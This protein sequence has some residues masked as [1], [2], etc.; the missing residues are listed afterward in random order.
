[1]V[2]SCTD[3]KDVRQCPYSL[4]EADFD[5]DAATLPR[6]QSIKNDAVERG[7]A[8]GLIPYGFRCSS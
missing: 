8:A 3:E 4:T 2:S 1:M 5:D 6:T 7:A